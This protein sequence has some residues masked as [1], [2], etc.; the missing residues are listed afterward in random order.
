MKTE[1]KKRRLI[2]IPFMIVLTLL[3][4]HGAI[5]AYS[6]CKEKE[7]DLCAV[8]RY[9]EDVSIYVD[10]SINS[11]LPRFYV[12]DNHSKQ[13]LSKS[14][15]AHGCGGGSTITRPTFSN[16]IGSNCSSLGVCRLTTISKIKG[17]DMPCIRLEGLS[18]TNSNVAKRGILIHEANFFGDEISIG[19]PIPVTKYISQGCFAISTETFK[20][21][22]EL[23]R[24]KKSIYLYSVYNECLPL[25]KKLTL[26]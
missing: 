2:V 18:K 3:L 26:L 15:C 23:L 25:K 5:R 22:Q 8:S 21:L 17:I 20:C 24:Q 12:Y 19:L 14:K 6:N 13:I 7:L 16:E 9:G 10:F 4:V 1:K 11:A